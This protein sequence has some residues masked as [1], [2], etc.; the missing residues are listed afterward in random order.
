MG[1]VITLAVCALFLAAGLREYEVPLLDQLELKTYDMR[2]RALD[3]PRP[4]HVTI[5]AID[6]Q[7]L[8]RVGRWPWSRSVHAELARRLDEAGAK[9]IAFD[10]FFSE[11]ESARADGQLARAL[12]ATKKTVLSTVFLLDQ[13]EARYLGEVGAQAGLKAIGPQAIGDAGGREPRYKSY[14]VIAN[15]PELQASALYAGHINVLPD[16]D[17]IYRRV[18]LVMLHGD[19]YFPSFDVQVA[20]AFNTDRQLD[21]KLD[22]Q[23]VVTLSIAGREFRP[24]TQGQLLVRYRGRAGTT[25]DRV[26]VADILDRKADP[27]LLRDRVVLIGGTATSLGDIRATPLDSAP[28]GVELRANVI[29]NLIDG[30]VIERPDWMALVDVT[31]ML[32]IGLLMVWLL[33]RLGISG[34][35]LLAAVLVGGYVALAV[36]LFRG[37]GLWLNLVYPSLLIVLLFATATLVSYFFTLSEKRYLKLA[38]QHYVPPAVVEDL[39]A[40]A[41]ALRLGGEKRRLTV[42]FSDIRGFTTLSE[43]MQPEELVKLMNEYFTVM[44][45][46]VF[47]E[48]G[49]LDKYIGDAIMAV[50]GAPVAETE[51]PKQAC[52]SALAMLSALETLQEKWKPMGLPVIGIGVGINTGPMIVGNMGSATRFNYT[53]VGDA[54]NLASRIESL[55]KTYG[56][57]ILISEYTYEDVKD[58]F[59]NVREV[60]SVRV[61]GR[62]QPVRLY[63]LF[64]KG[65]FTA[66]FLEEYRQA[67][68]AMNAGDYAR[69]AA[70]F[71]KLAG[72][73][74]GVSAFHAQR[75]GPDRRRV[76]EA[77][78]MS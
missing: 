46:R 60:D 23:G 45:D 19:R 57:S 24:D 55:N 59:S 20:R 56:T 58:E 53:V 2:M 10:I 9:V 68:A 16:A 25:F 11:R 26:S 78:I 27:A 77:T 7:S 41:G 63:E 8:A 32:A 13:R 74:D 12:G 15:I 6:E 33:P 44:T 47:A 18:P 66:D 50:Y 61:R 28:P 1:I 14:G 65:R 40:D 73:G 69:S 38:F 3:A 49:S 48:R 64:P 36:Y 62:E 22:D 35:G 54:V 4:Q 29:E 75:R 21:L 51:H 72:N 43:G 34:G 17:G 71:E 5:A 76:G 42:L 52:R 39:V 70:M 67:Y 31:M 30:R 37:E